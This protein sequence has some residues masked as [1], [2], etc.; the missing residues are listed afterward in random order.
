MGPC[1]LAGEAVPGETRGTRKRGVCSQGQGLSGDRQGGDGRSEGWRGSR[2][3]KGR[4]AE[5]EDRSSAGPARPCGSGRQV[6]LCTR[7]KGRKRKRALVCEST[8]LGRFT[9]NGKSVPPTPDAVQKSQVPG[10]HRIQRR[11]GEPSVS[12]YR[13]TNQQSPDRYSLVRFLA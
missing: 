11:I 5:A 1:W 6:K 7:E 9:G 3:P 12:G 13:L 4:E 10:G 2:N 8:S